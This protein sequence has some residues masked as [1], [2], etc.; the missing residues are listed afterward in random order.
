MLQALFTAAGGAL[1]SRAPQNVFANSGS[2]PL[3]NGTVRLQEA[4]GTTRDSPYHEQVRSFRLQ[5]GTVE[6]M[7]VS[8]SATQPLQIFLTIFSFFFF[9]MNCV[10]TC[11]HTKKADTLGR[12][13]F[14]CSAT[15]SLAYAYVIFSGFRHCC[16]LVL[17]KKADTTD[18][19]QIWRA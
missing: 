18:T 11:M 3:W 9:Q 4:H 1:Q 14:S 13:V 2:S 10:C 7:K 15:E 16:T 17:S 12:L 6:S 19:G 5:R 8:D